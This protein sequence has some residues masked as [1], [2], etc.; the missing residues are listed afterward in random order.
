MLVTRF[1]P[2][3]FRNSA[4]VMPNATS[5]FTQPAVNVLHKENTLEIQLAAP[6][7]TKEDF[8]IVL[9]KDLLK[10]TVTKEQSKLSDDT[11][12]WRNEFSFQSFEKSFRLPDT[13]NMETLA[14]VYENGILKISLQKLPEA[15]PKA[16][17]IA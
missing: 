5:V 7:L 11:K 13:L 17:S 14:A 15:T 1:K 9:E 8:K 12:V 4:F 2:V 16:I 10:I 3:Q 6:G